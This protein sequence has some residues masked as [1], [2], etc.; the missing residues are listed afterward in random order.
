MISLPDVILPKIKF[1]GLS[2]ELT[3]LHA[4]ELDDRQKPKKMAETQIPEG[5]FKDALLV[6]KNSFVQILKNLISTGNFSSPYVAISFPES[7]AYTREHVL[8]V[9]PLDEVDEAISWRAQELFP[10]PKSE[11]YFDWK[12]MS[13]TDKE[14]IVSV[15]AVPK[16][17]LD[18]IVAAIISAGLK[19]LRLEP[20]ASALARLLTLEAKE[21]SFLIEINQHGS[22]ITLVEGEKALFTTVVPISKDDTPVSYLSTIDQTLVDIVAFYTKKQILSQGKT[23]VIVTGDLASQEWVGHLNSLLK[24]PTYILKSKMQHSRFNK[25]F[26]SAVAKIA[27]PLDGQSINLLPSNIQIDFDNERNINFYIGILVRAVIITFIMVLISFGS[28]LA[29]TVEKQR[30]EIQVKLVRQILDTQKP[31]TQKLLLLN[32][33]AKNIVALAPRRKTPA[34]ILYDLNT[35]ITEGIQISSWDFDDAKQTIKITGVAATREALLVFKKSIENIGRFDKVFLPLE[36]L[37]NP[38]QVIF[39]ISFLV[40]K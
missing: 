14:Y 25:A 32:A 4:V 30:F 3:S 2:I 17:V 40:K 15:V 12:I 21:H 7:F 27:P 6:D 13:I 38:S 39:T 26:T 1:F 11:I 35:A 28:Y 37:E 10:F 31:N 24:Y 5:I 34:E 36:S 9:I 8:P 29:V 22:Y 33:Q 16:K 18:P 23:S 19:P 20:D